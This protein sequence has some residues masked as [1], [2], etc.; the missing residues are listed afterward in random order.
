[1]IDEFAI[2]DILIP[3]FR[4]ILEP[5]NSSY[6]LVVDPSDM[7]KCNDPYSTIKVID[8]DPAGQMEYG[9]VIS[10]ESG[11][12]I[13]QEVKTDLY[14]PVSIQCIGVGA[15][16]RARR[17]QSQLDFPSVAPALSNS[18]LSVSS[19]TSVINLTKKNTTNNEP[20]YQFEI[21]FMITDGNFYEPD[22]ADVN[23]G[24]PGCPVV[25]TNVVD[26]QEV[27]ISQTLIPDGDDE[28]LVQEY[29]I[30]LTDT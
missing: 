5:N 12:V 13:G 15:S 19:K 20:R 23:A 8:L 17:L 26:I 6:R 28:G 16:T 2:T 24:L 1:M 29:T 30:E 21:L 7:D 3:L 27:P 4:P 18:G 10:N 9:G 22:E 25:D 14:V 11:E